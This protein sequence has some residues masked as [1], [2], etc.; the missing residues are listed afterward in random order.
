MIAE[1]ATFRIY[2]DIARGSLAARLARSIIQYLCQIAFCVLRT[3]Y[4]IKLPT[5]PYF[6]AESLSSLS[7]E[8]IHKEGNPSEITTRG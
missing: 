7:F 1:L 6:C 8:M 2:S 5:L 3:V 4:L